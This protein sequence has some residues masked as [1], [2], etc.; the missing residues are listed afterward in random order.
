MRS[1]AKLG[2]EP[3]YK[4]REKKHSIAIGR[5]QIYGGNAPMTFRVWG[6]KP[7]LPPCFRRLWTSIVYHIGQV[8]KHAWKTDQSQCPSMIWPQCTLDTF[9]LNLVAMIM[10]M[11][12]WMDMQSCSGW[13]GSLGPKQGH[14]FLSIALR[15]LPKPLP[16]SCLAT[17]CKFMRWPLRG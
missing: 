12:S 13:A 14:A 10:M 2:L 1:L 8:K 17:M 3:T 6:R 4:F 7:P 5:S 9:I 11:Q 15:I 16:I